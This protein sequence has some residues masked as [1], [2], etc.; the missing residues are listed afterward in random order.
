M[1]CSFLQN[2]TENNTF[3]QKFVNF[4][5]NDLLFLTCKVYFFRWHTLMWFSIL[6]LNCIMFHTIKYEG[7]LGYALPLR[8][9]LPQSTTYNINS[10]L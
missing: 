9:K 1:P 7:V 10:L 5:V 6:K 2:N 3:N 4:H 8:G